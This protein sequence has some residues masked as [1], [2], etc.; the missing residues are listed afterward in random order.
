MFEGLALNKLGQP[1]RLL[2]NSLLTRNVLETI[3]RLSGGNHGF[4]KLL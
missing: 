3:A 4:L 1:H 2:G